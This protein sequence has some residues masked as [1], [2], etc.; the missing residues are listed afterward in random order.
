M[1]LNIVFVSL[2]IFL[3]IS[4]V[5]YTGEQ[6]D[7]M[8]R[9]NILKEI[10]ISDNWK[11]I[12]GVAINELKIYSLPFLKRG[13]VLYKA[14]SGSIF[15]TALSPDNKKIAF[16]VYPRSMAG[17]E[18]LYVI[19]S[20]GTNL[21]K[22]GEFDLGVVS[23]TSDNK[24]LILAKYTAED[25]FYRN[26][27]VDFYKF[28]IASKE[29]KFLCSLEHISDHTE[30]LL[31]PK[32]SKLLYG[33]SS[34]NIILYDIERQEAVDMGIKGYSPAWSPDGQYIAYQGEDGNCYIMNP[35]GSKEKLL[36]NTRGY[37]GKIDLVWSPDSQYVL[38]LRSETGPI[39]W[40]TTGLSVKDA[41][42]TVYYVISRNSKS[43]MGLGAL[44]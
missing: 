1:N 30:Q 3:G 41:S 2:I 10:E 43:V 15:S 33:D 4:S 21:V 12:T 19:D 40:L 26:R 5:G 20:D 6:G 29:K 35:D 36:W 31:S 37:R 44:R 14:P 42:E 24:S 34:K 39:R 18:E 32:G 28:N 7:R 11:W 17:Y 23:F 27:S 25:E 22:L 13:T 9:E 16:T 8:K 38:A